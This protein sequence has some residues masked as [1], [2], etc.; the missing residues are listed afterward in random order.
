M[1]VDPRADVDSIDTVR[2][3]RGIDSLDAVANCES[4]GSVLWLGDHCTERCDPAH[5]S[6][7]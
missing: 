2:W 7:P 5:K 3:I 4:S 1:D 6:H